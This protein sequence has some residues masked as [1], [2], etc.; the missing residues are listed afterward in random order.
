M[1]GPWD[2]P[3]SPSPDDQ[4]WPAEDFASSPPRQPSEPW[5]SDDPWQERREP[6]EWDAWSPASTPTDDYVPEDPP[7]PSSD[8]WAESWADDVPGLPS[9][10]EAAAE[11]GV[12]DE[13]RPSRE[14][15][16]RYFST[17]EPVEAPAADSYERSDEAAMHEPAAAEPDVVAAGP[18]GPT[19]YEPAI[20]TARD[21][22]VAEVV[23]RIPR[24]E[25][26]SSDTDPWGSVADEFWGLQEAAPHEA[27]PEEA[28]APEAAAP[29]AAAPGAETVDASPATEPPHVE[30]P[31]QRPFEVPADLEPPPSR[32]ERAPIVPAWEADTEDLETAS[33]VA[34]ADRVAEHIDYQSAYE[35]LFPTSLPPVAEDEPALPAPALDEGPAETD[36]AVEA[37]PPTVEAEPSAAEAWSAEEGTPPAAEQSRPA[38]EAAPIL[39]E[40]PATPPPDPVWAADLWEEEP[41]GGAARPGL[42]EGDEAEGEAEPAS[43]APTAESASPESAPASSAVAVPFGA[44][45]VWA[46]SASRP[47]VSD[48]PWASAT[49]AATEPPVPTSGSDQEEPEPDWQPDDWR[50]TSSAT[51][52]L[53]ASWSPPRP[54][55]PEELAGLQPEAGR[56]RT[57]LGG[58]TDTDDEV[59]EQPSTAEQAV[60]WLIGF[61]LLLAGMV[62][63]LLALIFAGDASL[64]GGGAGPSGSDDIF[65]V[66]AS[67]SLAPAETASPTP[68]PTATPAPA[69]TQA[70]AIDYGDIPIVYQ[71]RSTAL[72]PIYLLRRDFA[73]EEEP[74][75]LAQDPD[76]DVR[77][78]AWAPDG[79]VGAGL[80][81]DLLISIEPGT[82]KR[83]L[84]DGAVSLTFGDDASTVYAVRITEDAA[85]DVATI[86]A[87]DYG[88]GE[89]EELAS[90]SYPRPALE[91]E[92][93]LGEARFADDGG[94][95]RLYW[96]QDDT[97]H[98][99]SV[100]AGAWDIDPVS[101]EV[102]ESDAS[103]VLWSPGGGRRIST[104]V[105]EDVTTIGVHD[106]ATEEPSAQTS[107][108]GLVSHVRWSPGGERV[109]FTVGRSAPGG[110]VLQDLFLWD[111]EDGTQPMQM[112]DS[113]AAFGAEWLGGASRWERD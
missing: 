57:S 59:E 37:R 88:S 43:D 76:L 16:D 107:V 70:A 12:S 100:G 34:P 86:L 79:T 24:V 64:G 65:A 51:Q 110:G 96:M 99:W 81:A 1:S 36:P 104:T 23:E 54:S 98:L 2:R 73:V 13:G 28:L 97:L 87:I 68:L 39:P 67:A 47:S 5:S 8:P 4:D 53:P 32:D 45:P 42:D 7:P 72:A 33:E 94:A 62:I 52:V 56:I 26:W 106:G 10:A 49:A 40:A 90:I 50:D 15:P 21:E 30:E 113:G 19:P 31:D 101:G 105:S 77:A 22:P 63:V 60:P 109:T 82:E 78:F 6:S 41:A 29:E 84:A 20:E 103:P 11:A 48:P 35:S 111:L 18:A 71:G 85:D 44:E 3:S 58:I 91:E 89:T 80:Y 95:V 17:D 93:A 38:A 74:V 92:S 25:P 108:D 75:V 14:D 61:I 27:P 9:A 112:T 102:A 69:P 46:P 55:S 66:G 83:N